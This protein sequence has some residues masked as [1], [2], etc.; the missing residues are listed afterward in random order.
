MEVEAEQNG[1]TATTWDNPQI[2]SDDVKLVH[3]AYDT[4]YKLKAFVHFQLDF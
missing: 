4:E 3:D 1:E 2:A